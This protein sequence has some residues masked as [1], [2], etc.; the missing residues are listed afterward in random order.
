MDERTKKKHLEALRFGILYLEGHKAVAV[1]EKL[2][3]RDI[4]TAMQAALTALGFEAVASEATFAGIKQGA[5]KVTAYY[6]PKLAKLK[7]T[8]AKKTQEQA[9]IHAFPLEGSSS[10]QDNVNCNFEPQLAGGF[11]FRHIGLGCPREA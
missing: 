4:V 11:D 1:R 3:A 10:I 5:D 9:R 2:S 6:E 8:L 7:A